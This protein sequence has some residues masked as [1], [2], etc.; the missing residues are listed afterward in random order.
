MFLLWWMT[1]KRCMEIRNKVIDIVEDN[2]EK[3]LEDRYED[4]IRD[5][6]KNIE[7]TCGYEGHEVISRESMFTGS[8]FSEYLKQR[9]SQPCPKHG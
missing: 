3:L 2:I 8:E 9:L 7:C 5:R 6:E 4:F 1:F